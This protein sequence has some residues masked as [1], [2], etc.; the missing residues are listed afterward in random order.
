VQIGCRVNDS[1]LRRPHQG[2]CVEPWGRG[3]TKAT[4][5]TSPSFAV[6]LPAQT[7][8]QT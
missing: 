3:T 2:F 6:K 7:L 1:H 5:T 4:T 8:L